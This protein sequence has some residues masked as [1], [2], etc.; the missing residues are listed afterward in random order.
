MDNHIFSLEGKTAIVTG[1]A[2]GIG[3]A[4]SM[5]F[6][7]AGAN[8]V[9]ADINEEKGNKTVEELKEK[10]V[11]ALFCELDVRDHDQIER[12]IQSTLDKFGKIDILMNNAGIGRP[13]PTTEVTPKDWQDVIDINLS[14]VFFMSQAVGKVMIRQGYGNI[15]NTA[16]MSAFIANYQSEQASYYASKAG[17]VML[18]KALAAE[19][20]KYG[21]RVNGIAPGVTLTDQTNWIF[22]DPSKEEYV[23][24]I[25]DWTPLGRPARAEELGG[26][27]VYLASEASSYMTGHIMVIDGGHTIH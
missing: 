9:V 6:A 27:C 11:D 22:K 5:A 12:T 26:A 7:D 14:G 17:V 15:I 3:K 8:V 23:K 19:W 20:A 18:T 2:M 16:S 10:G 24:T 21:I 1:A 4:I 25:M 13:G